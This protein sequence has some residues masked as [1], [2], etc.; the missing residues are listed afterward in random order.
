MPYQHV[1]PHISIKIFHSSTVIWDCLIHIRFN[2]KSTI[3]ACYEIKIH[4]ICKYIDIHILTYLLHG[5]ESFLRSQP[6]NFADIDIHIHILFINMA[7]LKMTGPICFST[8]TSLSCWHSV[9][10][11]T[12]IHIGYEEKLLNC[13]DTT[14]IHAFQ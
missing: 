11:R 2:L 9:L 8:T 14:G 12:F 4:R 3:I 10:M 1:I 5:A 13:S 6:V 7:M